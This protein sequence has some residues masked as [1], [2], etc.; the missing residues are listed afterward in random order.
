MWEPIIVQLRWTKSEPKTQGLPLS[1]ETSNQHIKYWSRD[2]SSKKTNEP[3]TPILSQRV[4]VG[5]RKSLS[6]TLNRTILQL[7]HSFTSWKCFTDLKLK[8]FTQ[9]VALQKKNPKISQHGEVAIMDL[10]LLELLCPK[11]LSLHRHHKTLS[12]RRKNGVIFHAIVTC[13]MD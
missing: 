8:R 3:P 4:I 13:M 1:M 7:A 10:L 5:S 2:N 11:W 12:N 6:T 9:K